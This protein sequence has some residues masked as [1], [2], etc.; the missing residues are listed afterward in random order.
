MTWFVLIQNQ[1]H[2]FIFKNTVLYFITNLLVFISL[3]FRESSLA[4]ILEGIPPT[5]SKKTKPVYAEESSTVT[6][7]VRLVA[8]PEPELVWYLNGQPLEESDD[9][10]LSDQSDMHSYVSL[11]TIKSV[12]KSE[13]EGVYTVL[14]KNREGEA[15]MDIP[16]KVR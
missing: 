14:A 10:V 8:V 9:V 13:H 6:L 3:P 4:D 11:V 5:F 16:V 7:E 15:K 12:R 1:R 2:S